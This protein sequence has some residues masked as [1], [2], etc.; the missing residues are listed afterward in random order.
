M[1][2]SL[3]IFL[4]FVLHCHF[5]YA[6]ELSVKDIVQ[7]RDDTMRGKSSFGEYEM[8]VISPRWKR[9][10]KF[11]AWSSGAENSFIDITYPKKDKG[12]TFLRIKTNMWQYVPRIEK[13]IK[14]P[15]SMM[16]QSWMGT[17]FTNDDLVKESSIINDYT[18]RLL[19]EDTTAYTIES[20]PKPDAAVVWGKI[21]QR[22]DKNKF[23][24][25]KDEFYDEDG[26]L[27]KRLL[28]DE[29]QRLPDRVYP[30]RWTMES[31]MDERKGHKTIIIIHNL[32]INLPLEKDIF[33]MRAL[34]KYSR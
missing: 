12:I 23:V 21:I 25:V 16:L 19:R 18:H 28:Y 10:V 1:K 24:P 3:L 15:P 32:Q 30:M 34:K 13:T 17:D 8:L 5:N 22:I 9:T 2:K 26:V 20:L 11:K 4:I 31:L 14:I 6:S 27:I 7:K 33:S 29:L